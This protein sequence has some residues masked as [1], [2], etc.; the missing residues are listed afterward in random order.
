[1][2]KLR[3]DLVIAVMNRCCGECLFPKVWK[4]AKAVWVPKRDGSSR[5]IS[6][7]P[8]LGRVLDKLMNRMAY[9]VLVREVGHLLAGT[10][11][12]QEP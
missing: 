6:L 9:S 5:P 1:M 10:V 2:L 4:V 11:W 12:I 7:P 3:G 8:V